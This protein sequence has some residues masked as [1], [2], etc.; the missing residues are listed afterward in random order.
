MLRAPL[1][2]ILA[3]ALGA[4][5]MS[6][7]VGTPEVRQGPSFQQ[8][9][10]RVVLT[11]ASCGS[12]EDLCTDAM[13]EGTNSFVANELKFAGF[14]VVDAVKIAREARKDERAHDEVRQFGER[15]LRAANPRQ[16]GAIFSDLTPTARQGLMESAD[17]QGV[18]TVGIQLGTADGIGPGRTHQVLIRLGLGLE[19]D[20]VW[21]SRCTADSGRSP[22]SEQAGDNAPRCALS[23]ALRQ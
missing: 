6:G 19:D 18:V 23:A 20:L 17:A 22:D 2:L 5:L 3:L 1:L 15:I 21:V 7:C 4:P 11:P 16:H 8:R 10:V 14:S 13:V 12:V 9:P